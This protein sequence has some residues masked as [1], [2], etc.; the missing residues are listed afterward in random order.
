V[1]VQKA[2][3][4]FTSPAYVGMPIWLTVESDKPNKIHYPVTLLSG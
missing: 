4:S 1:R 2:P 3:I